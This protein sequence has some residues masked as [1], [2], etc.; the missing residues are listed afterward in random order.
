MISED[1]LY[2]VECRATPVVKE[3]IAELRRLRLALAEHHG[4]IEPHP[5]YNQSECRACRKALRSDS[6]T[7]GTGGE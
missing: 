1:A 5:P 6:P 7:E 3:I 4:G 2:F